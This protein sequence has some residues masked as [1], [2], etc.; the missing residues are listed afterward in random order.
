MK[1]ILEIFKEDFKDIK[2]NYTVLVIVI[3]LAILPSLYAWFNIEASWDPYGNTKNMKVAITNKDRGTTVSNQKVNVGD[4][5][6]EKLHDNNS[7]GWQFVDEKTALE[8]VKTG[9]YYA[10][11]IIPEDFSKDLTSLITSDVKKGTIIYTVNEKINAIAPKITEKG[12][13]TIQLQVNQTVVKTVSEIILGFTNEIGVG[14]EKELPKLSKVENS[15][16]DLQGKFDNIDKTMNTAS[17]ATSKLNDTVTNVKGDLPTIKN[18]IQDTKKLS[19]DIKSFLQ[20]TNN[21]VN[22]IAPLIKTDLNLIVDISSSTS[23][24]TSDLNSALESGS[25]DATKILN[26]ISAKLAS[27]KSLNNSLLDFIKRLDELSSL[28]SF[29]GVI[30]KLESINSKVESATVTVNDIKDQIAK[31]QKPS[32]SALN[33]LK[34]LCDD[35]G[36]LGNGLL[37]NFDSEILRPINSIFEGG[38]KVANEIITVLDKAE[39]KLPQIEEILSLCLDLSND[40]EDTVKLIQEKLPLAKDMINE[41]V[42]VLD[43]INN[44]DDM[45][46]LVD[47]LESDILSKS[48][49]L[50]EPVQVKTEK[51]Y[52][53]ENYGAGMTPFYSVL[54]TWVGILLLSALL[55]TSVKGNYKPYEAYFGRAL[56]FLSIALVQGFIIGVGDILLLGVK[57]EHPVLFVVLLMFTSMVFN[58]IVYSLVSVFGN[59]GKAMAIV[60]LVLQIAAAGGTF[61]IQVTPKFFQVIN[62]MLPFTYAISASREALGG[63]YAPNLIKDIIAMSI[64]MAIAICVNVFLK[65]PINKFGAPLKKKFSESRMTGH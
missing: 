18:T 10:S 32:A 16:K 61:P 50:K 42:T 62:P 22:R 27:I 39:N 52:P 6:I 3:G 28:H 49:F 55:T 64:F 8:G 41:I 60:L 63:I 5:L 59:I 46:K 43:G 24:L 40:A 14:I 31:G 57:I 20:D 33:D 12:A 25:E 35:I 54:S 1:N 56:T 7:L 15:L 37:N 51:L 17:K 30:N 44:S 65:G 13:S 47:L 36:S 19:N 48:D 21:N 11:V 29:T 9:E 23:S 34:R 53:I 58:F 4:Q 2:G 26:N 38:V 45:Q